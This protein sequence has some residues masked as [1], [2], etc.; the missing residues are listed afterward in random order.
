[1]SKTYDKI[2]AVISLASNSPGAPTG[3]GQQAEYLVERL[4]RHGAKVAALSNYGLEGTL[5][6]LKVKGGK[7]AHYPRGF[8]QYSDDIIPDHH[9]KHRRGRED[10]P[11][12]VVTL[13]DV[14]VYRNPALDK[15]P[16]ISWVPLD[17]I[18]LPPLVGRWLEK[19]NVTPVT[20]APHGKRQL[21]AAGIDNVYIPHGIDTKTYSYTETFDGV[22][23][24]EYMGVKGDDFLIGMV[25]ANK[26]NKYYHR[27][28]FAENLAAVSFFMKDHPDTVLYIHTDGSPAL[29]GF[30]LGTLLASVGIPAD[31]VIFPDPVD[32]RYG[33]TKKQL[34]ALYSAFDVLLAPSYGEGFGIPTVEAQSAGTRAIASSWAASADLVA[35]DGWLV[36]GHVFWDEGQ[37]SWWKLPDVTSIVGALKQ[38]YDAPRG[39]SEVA[40]EFALQFDVDK[41]WAESW[42]PFLKGY[43]S[44]S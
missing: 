28:A 36:E 38:A 15:L 30:N 10:K 26:A 22:P 9:A 40:R 44:G 4:V 33:Y 27:K 21:D 2:D 12:A 3:Y 25:A 23:T 18:T 24:R 1:M 19:P 6:E 7:V 43:L 32:L 5:G 35:E 39:P 20:M 34:A 13:Y 42:L 11:H 29:G 14:W 16:I 41:V 17:H 37:S 31:K 8:T